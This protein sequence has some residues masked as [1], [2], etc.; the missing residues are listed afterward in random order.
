MIAVDTN[1]LVYAHRRE[2]PLHR[3]ANEALHSL[4]NTP[5]QWAIAWA[6]VH[7]FLSVVTNAKAMGTPTPLDQAFAQVEAWLSGGSVFLLHEGANHMALLRDL[8]ASAAIRGG[9]FHD[10]RIAAICLD[11]GVSEL[12]TADRDFSRFPALKTRNPL[13]G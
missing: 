6:C 2:A 13:V 7:E 1:I 4:I 11:H 12:W 5:S 8:A 9:Q 10:A 3:K